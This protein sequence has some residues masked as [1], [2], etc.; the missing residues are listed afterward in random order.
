M[1]NS[2]NIKGQITYSGANFDEKV[3]DYVE[4]L[5]KLQ[6]RTNI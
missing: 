5:K 3:I 2:D 6:K 1:I 4:K